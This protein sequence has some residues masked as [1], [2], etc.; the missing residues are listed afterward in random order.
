MD[1]NGAIIGGGI[2]GLSAAL[3]AQQ[4]GVQLPVFEKRADGYAI[5]HLLW[6]A[7]NG[8]HMLETLGLVDEVL[9]RSTPQE[10]MRFSTASLRVL[11]S[12]DC[13]ELARTNRYPIVAIRRR[14]LHQIMSEALQCRGG[15]ITFGGE[16]ENLEVRHDGVLVTLRSR[17]PLRLSYVLAADG[18]GSAIRSSLFPTSTVKYQG[19]R[20]WL[21]SSRSPVGRAFVGKT[22]EMW[23]RGTRFVATSL[24]DEHI[25]WSALER[26]ARYEGQSLPIPADTIDRL[27]GIFATYHPHV[28]EILSKASPEELVRC[29]FS[30]VE[31]LPAYYRGR[32]CLLG[33]AAHG[34]P[35]NMGQGASLAL[36]DAFS[37]V[38]ELAASDAVEAAFSSYDRGRRPRVSRV[39]R[40]ANQ[41]NGAFQPTSRVAALLRNAVTAIFPQ[42]L[43]QRKMAR[44]Y[45]VPFAT[46]HL[47]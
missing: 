22:V 12:L 13:R 11:L 10:C 27:R 26:P 47:N 8:L 38:R 4:Q 46:P 31:G 41:M 2:A 32:V 1:G 19:I 25:Y 9:A 15:T 39:V 40:L 20:T 17:P 24:D 34:M 45:A 18:I 36:E 30:V 23:G 16:L 43:T 35:P 7:P 33:D 29:N 14:S 6:L 37:A 5:D 21:G 44:L 42:R 28:G 3:F